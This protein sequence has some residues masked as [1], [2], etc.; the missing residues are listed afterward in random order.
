[1]Q[2]HPRHVMR[3]FELCS[4]EGKQKK[5]GRAPIPIVICRQRQSVFLF[6]CIAVFWSIANQA[7]DQPPFFELGNGSPAA[8]PRCQPRETLRRF[9][10]R[11]LVSWPSGARAVLRLP[12][13]VLAVLCGTFAKD[14]QRKDAELTPPL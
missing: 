1:M 12:P 9:A 5:K 8:L 14:S 13:H 2:V 7:R 4:L 6:L 11:V 3:R 10:I